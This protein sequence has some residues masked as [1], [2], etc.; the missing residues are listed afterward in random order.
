MGVGTGGMIRNSIAIQD[1]LNYRAISASFQSI[2][3]FLFFG[4]YMY[5]IIPNELSISTFH[6][7]PRFP[8]KYNKHH[9][10]EKQDLTIPRD[11]DVADRLIEFSSSS[12]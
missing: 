2:W 7:L 8:L 6:D 12:T 9:S 10:R 1:G 5:P 11:L 4:T 3:F